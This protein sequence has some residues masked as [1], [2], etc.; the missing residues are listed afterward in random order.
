MLT[1]DQ[2]Y[3]SS[4]SLARDGIANE[5]HCLHSFADGVMR[6]TSVPVHLVA[7]A[8]TNIISSIRVCVCVNLEYALCVCVCVCFKDASP[9]LQMENQVGKVRD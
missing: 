1:S 5:L 2:V 6:D 9:L 3:S 4:R 8:L 7:H